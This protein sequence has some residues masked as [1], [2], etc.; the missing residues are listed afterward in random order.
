M[1]D[2]C[3]M[4]RYVYTMF[5]GFLL[6]NAIDVTIWQV[7]GLWKCW[8][9]CSYV[10]HRIAFEQHKWHNKTGVGSLQMSRLEENKG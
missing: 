8:D 10:V 9:S 1:Q 5:I 4:S 6:N 7:Q 2:L 3:K